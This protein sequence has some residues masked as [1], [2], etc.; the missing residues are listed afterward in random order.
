MS[1]VM[2]CNFKSRFYPCHSSTGYQV[3]TISTNLTMATSISSH[4]E[5]TKS[6]SDSETEMINQEVE[7]LK[8]QRNKVRYYFFFH[9]LHPYYLFR[10]KRSQQIFSTYQYLESLY[11][12]LLCCCWDL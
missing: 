6:D 12:L 2:R 1:V 3:N 7:R 8:R 10:N 11:P 5:V 9:L 4:I